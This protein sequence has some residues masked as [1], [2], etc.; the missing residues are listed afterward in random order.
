[1]HVKN[2]HDESIPFTENQDAQ[3]QIESRRANLEIQ[4][5]RADSPFADLH[6]LIDECAVC[7]A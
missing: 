7:L 1:M 3:S 2:Q 6:L 4:Q 5:T